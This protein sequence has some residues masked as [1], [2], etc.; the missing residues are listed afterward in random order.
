MVWN[1]GNEVVFEESEGYGY[2]GDEDRCKLN[3]VKYM[4]RLEKMILVFRV[5]FFKLLKIL[6]VLWICFEIFL[7]LNMW[8]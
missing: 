3:L 6:F 5:I 7:I 8:L 1:L 2:L 4:F